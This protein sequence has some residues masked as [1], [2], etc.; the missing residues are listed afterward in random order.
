MKQVTVINRVT[1]ATEVWEAKNI[2]SMPSKESLR[3]MRE[4][5]KHDLISFIIEFKGLE[6]GLGMWKV[7]EYDLVVE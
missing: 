2:K 3:K 5:E 1:G 7:D 4:H 6:Y